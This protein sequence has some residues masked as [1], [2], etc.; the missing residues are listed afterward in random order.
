MW[1]SYLT[2]YVLVLFF[3]KLKKEE[4]EK[5]KRQEEEEEWQKMKATQRE[6]VS[7]DVQN[8]NHFYSKNVWY[9]TIWR[10][11]GLVFIFHISISLTNKNSNFFWT[12]ICVGGCYVGSFLTKHSHLLSPLLVSLF[13][14][15]MEN[16]Q[17]LTK[18][19]G[20]V[21]PESHI[22]IHNRVIRGNCG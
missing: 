9:V 7:P 2:F 10:T 14:I 13:S 12:A 22:C 19:M 17:I 15:L 11:A 1:L 4:M 5:K 8:Q 3:F 20:E 6:K 18:L 21:P 16:P